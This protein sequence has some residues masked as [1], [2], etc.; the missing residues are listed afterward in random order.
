MPSITRVLQAITVRGI[1]S[2]S[3]WQMRQFPA[4][5]RPGDLAAIL[6]NL[7]EEEILFI[8]EI[9]VITGGGE[10]NELAHR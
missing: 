7:S 5:E 10:S 6:T 2:I 8:D 1:F 4:I 3:T 9:H